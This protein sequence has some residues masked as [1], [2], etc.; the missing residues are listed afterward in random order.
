MVAGDL[1]CHGAEQRAQALKSDKDRYRISQV[2]PLQREMGGVSCE[3]LAHSVSATEAPSS[4]KLWIKYN[5]SPELYN[6]TVVS[7]VVSNERF[8]PR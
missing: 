4:T 8:V 1:M 7:I 3:L 2:R 6:P 5:T